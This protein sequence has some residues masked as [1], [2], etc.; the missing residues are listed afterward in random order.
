VEGSLAVARRNAGNAQSTPDTV[1]TPP[2][3]QEAL[4]RHV[5]KWRALQGLSQLE[6]ARRARLSQ[7]RISQIETGRI[8]GR[9]PL[10]TL[11]DLADALG[12]GLGDLAPTELLDDLLDDEHA[13]TLQLEQTAVV[14]P[15]DRLVGRDEDVQ[16]IARLLSSNVRLLSLLGPGGVGKSQLAL[17]ATM[18]ISD[19]FADRA[20]V[21][22]AD[23]RDF[24]TVLAAAAQAIGIRERDAQPV[25]DRLLTSLKSRRLLLVLDNVEQVVDHVARFAADLLVSCP[26]VALLVTSRVPL[27]VDGERRYRVRPLVV[28]LSL[29][30]VSCS[31][32]AQASAVQLF[33]ERARAVL[34][35]FALDESN[36]NEVAAVTSL[37]EGLPLAIELAAAR[38]GVFS[39]GQLL[40]HLERD[41][42]VLRSNSRNRPRRQRSLAGSI[43]WSVDLL[44]E[45]ERVLFR[46]LAVFAGGFTLDAARQIAAAEDEN[47]EHADLEIADGIGSLLDHHLLIRIQEGAGEPR[48][49][50]PRTV[51]QYARKLLDSSADALPTRRT[52]LR[53]S[54]ALVEAMA[55]SLF[56]AEETARYRQ[57]DAEGT[58]LHDALAWGLRNQRADDFELGLRL[59]AALTEY[60][61][62]RGS[63]SLGRGWLERAVALSAGCEP[64]L[65]RARCLIGICLLEA[66]QASREAASVHGEQG[67]AMAKALGDEW[68]IGRA[69]L[70][71]G[72]LAQMAGD[73]ERAIAL[74]LEALSSFR[75]QG[76]RA[77]TAF[78]LANLGA[79]H[80]RRGDLDSAATFSEEGLAIT[81]EIGDLWDA[82]VALWVL[83]DVA[84]SRG[85]PDRA[86]THYAESLE[87]G[88][89][90]ASQREAAKALAGL[91]IV[92]ASSDQPERAARFLAAAET[93]LR[94]IGAN[95][96]PVDVPDWSPAIATVEGRLGSNRFAQVRNSI[97]LDRVI[98]EG[99]GLRVPDFQGRRHRRA[100][101]TRPNPKRR[102]ARTG[103]A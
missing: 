61:Y 88:W 4:G 25:R 41:F 75:R 66:I 70:L 71:L 35:D 68:A 100:L 76:E 103:A 82:S 11:T 91:G 49:E 92:D 33:I 12:V 74:Q 13:V 63:L 93:L 10:R 36:V 47:T 102:R 6:L 50:M 39:P 53:W 86:R 20:I 3:A 85:M 16:A 23:A 37:L 67:L 97:S 80:Y 26:Q 84:R 9:L 5:R 32:A 46:R 69:L 7:S 60:W 58:N 18:A 19:S 81:R 101:P 87:L 72:D 98:A 44:K 1:R 30:Q 78:A 65:G 42:G 64:S 38:I 99:I 54:L 28:P 83:G 96:P 79:V 8:H 62:L 17:H 56:T 73:D 52:H 89:R 22:L 40:L 90:H 14:L 15:V 27:H 43:G 94:R 55:P 34:P 59:A 24:G 31:E 77:W 45:S 29:P 95:V 2:P 21:N 48:F 57:L 51:R